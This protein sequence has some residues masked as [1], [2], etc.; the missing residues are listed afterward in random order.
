M[1]LR[2][3][4]G[5]SYPSAAETLQQTKKA[6]EENKQKERADCYD[7]VFGSILVAAREGFSVVRLEAR[8]IENYDVRE[9]LKKSGFK[10]EK[11]FSL[12]S[13]SEMGHI[14]FYYVHWGKEKENTDVVEGD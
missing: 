12:Y 9:Y 6:I 5:Y 7:K 10:I 4:D 14:N 3:P 11:P 2:A 13:P 1:S 8:L